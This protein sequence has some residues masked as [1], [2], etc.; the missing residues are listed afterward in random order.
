M[1]TDWT[2]VKDLVLSGDAVLR[3]SS[4]TIVDS[5]RREDLN[6]LEG[7]RAVAFDE[8]QERAGLVLFQLPG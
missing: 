5:A 1:A 6:A 3:L 2:I 7:P 8:A 4:W